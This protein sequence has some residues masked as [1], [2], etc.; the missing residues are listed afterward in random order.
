[1]GCRPIVLG[2]GR[3]RVLRAP[4]LNPTPELGRARQRDGRGRFQAAASRPAAAP[5]QP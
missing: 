1:M 2:P 4:P 5:P 3:V